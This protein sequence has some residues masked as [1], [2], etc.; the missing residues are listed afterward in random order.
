[1]RQKITDTT[2]ILRNCKRL[3]RSGEMTKEQYQA[4]LIMLFD[5][6][7]IIEQKSTDVEFIIHFLNNKAKENPILENLNFSFCM[8]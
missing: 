2:R 1:M 8:N 4:T 6:V 3:F 7:S 5:N